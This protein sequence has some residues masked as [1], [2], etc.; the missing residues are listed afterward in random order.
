MTEYNCDGLYPLIACCRKVIHFQNNAIK[1]QCKNV[2]IV[3]FRDQLFVVFMNN[4]A[5]FL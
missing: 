3:Y 1:N 5:Y 4:A 2:S